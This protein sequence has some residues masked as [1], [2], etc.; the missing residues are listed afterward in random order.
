MSL[1]GRIVPV[2]DI[3]S[4]LGLVPDA[5]LG[6]GCHALVVQA[7]AVD[8]AIAVE[9]IVGLD[10]VSTESTDDETPRATPFRT[11]CVRPDGA[12]VSLLN[13]G[14]IA[15]ALRPRAGVRA[16]EDPA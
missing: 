4:V 1:R 16:K 10:S 14:R 5:P 2:V 3:R 15:E 8:L 7:G 12:A 13:V 11:W 6:R 9:E